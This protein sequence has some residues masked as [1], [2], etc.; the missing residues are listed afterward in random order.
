MVRKRV[1]YQLKGKKSNYVVQTM[2]L[3]EL[4]LV[5]SGVHLIR[6]Q[7][8]VH[9]KYCNGKNFTFLVVLRF[10]F[11]HS[12]HKCNIVWA[13]QDVCGYDTKRNET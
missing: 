6:P 1:H 4:L 5:A 13:I 7:I 9:G 2:L 10:I 12:T 8:C 3:M 11:L